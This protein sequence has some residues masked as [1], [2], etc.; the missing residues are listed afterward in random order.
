ME[1]YVFHNERLILGYKPQFHYG[2]GYIVSCCC[3]LLLSTGSS[4]SIT[5]NSPVK[6]ITP[7]TILHYYNL[8]LYTGSYSADAHCG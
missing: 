8:T 3:I 5:M 1:L 2:H 6:S 4:N 7:Q